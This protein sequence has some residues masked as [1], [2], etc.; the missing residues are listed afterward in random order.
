MANSPSSPHSVQSLGSL[1]F[2]VKT[3]S[4]PGGNCVQDRCGEIESISMTDSVDAKARSN[5]RCKKLLPRTPTQ[6]AVTLSE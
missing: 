4:S 5:T 1:C 3:Q 6:N 2:F